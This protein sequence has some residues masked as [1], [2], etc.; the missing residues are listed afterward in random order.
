MGTTESTL[1][2][3]VRKG[4]N[5]IRSALMGSLLILVFLTEELL[6]V[7]PLTYFCLHKSARAYLFP[8][9]V[10]IHYF[11]SGPMSADPVCL[12]PKSFSRPGK[13]PGLDRSAS[14][15]THTHTHTHACLCTRV[16]ACVGP[17]R[18]AALHT[19]LAA[20]VSA[21]FRD[22]P[23]DSSFKQQQSSPQKVDPSDA[24]SLNLILRSLG[25]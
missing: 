7:L 5:G 9:S 19:Q 15:H 6:G 1:P 2:S 24:S 22:P 10:K 17:L 16:R 21:G 14:V 12:Q 8:Q 11:S 18:R 25:V 20:S 23:P 13:S 4:T 3:R